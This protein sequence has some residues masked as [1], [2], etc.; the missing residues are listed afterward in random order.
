VY[1]HEKVYDVFVDEIVK[2]AALADAKMGNGMDDG[3]VYDPLNN[4]AQLDKVS[5]L[6]EDAKANGANI[7]CGGTARLGAGY[8][9]P[10]T[11]VTG[12][13][14]GVK[15]VDEEQFGPVLPVMPFS[16]DDEAVARANDS[17]F[18]LGGSVWSADVARANE[19]VAR[20]QCGTGW[21]NDHLA[22]TGGPFGGSKQSGLGYELGKSDVDAFTELQT[23]RLAK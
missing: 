19:M 8:F 13:R 15:L 9:Y 6:V 7:R 16:S 17:V 22:D 18:G 14:E 2:V 21:V 20:L 23:V 10:P 12:I 3:V 11:I 1:V 5:A 4:K